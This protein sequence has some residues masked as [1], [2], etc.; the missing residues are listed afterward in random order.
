MWGKVLLTAGILIVRSF[1]IE[2]TW[3]SLSRRGRKDWRD[4]EDCTDWWLYHEIV[5]DVV[6]HC[7]T[8]LCSVH[9]LFLLNLSLL[10]HNTM[11]ATNLLYI[12]VSKSWC[13]H[14]PMGCCPLQDRMTIKGSYTYYMKE[15]LTAELRVCRMAKQQRQMI[16][17]KR[18]LCHFWTNLL[19]LTQVKVYINDIIDEQKF[20]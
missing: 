10:Y 17:Q 11:Y 14:S 15:Q 9:F 7:Y 19:L 6:P 2:L 20:Y 5:K 1:Y 13:V 8:L 18:R 3:G 12:V 16:V 4:S